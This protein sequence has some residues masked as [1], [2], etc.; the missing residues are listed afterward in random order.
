MPITTGVKQ[1]VDAAER[2]IESL[3]LAEAKAMLGGEEAV[4]VDI[5]DI[6]ELQREGKI[7]GAIHAPLGMLEFWVDPA[8]PYHRDVFAQEKTYVL[9]CASAWRSAL[10]TQALQNMG[11]DNVCHIAGGFTA[12]KAAELP[13]EPVP[14]KAD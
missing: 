12:W 6:R 8:S 10:A 9:Y 5:R 3:S 2:E 1:L 7:K 11:M 13:M 14:V 4:F